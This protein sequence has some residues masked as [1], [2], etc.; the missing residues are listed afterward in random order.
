MPEINAAV[1]EKAFALVKM[2]KR[3]EFFFREVVCARAR[4]TRLSLTKRNK[5][6]DLEKDLK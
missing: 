1:A 5:F 2:R 6:E 4:A 3:R